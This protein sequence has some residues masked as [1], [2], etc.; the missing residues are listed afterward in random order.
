MKAYTVAKALVV[1]EHGELLLLRRSLSDTRRPGQWDM[2]G[3]GVDEGE[4]LIQAAIRET[5]EEA[6]ITLKQPKTIYATSKI[7]PFG[8]VTWIFVHEALSSTPEVILSDEHDAFQWLKLQDVIG[9]LEYDLHKEMLT[10]LL[11]NKLI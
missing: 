11:E 5:Q 10:Y 4:D 7:R 6:G 2:P 3:G 1:N 8:G 9:E